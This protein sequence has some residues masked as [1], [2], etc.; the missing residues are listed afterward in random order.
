[1]LPQLRLG[2]TTATIAPGLMLESGTG[3][4]GGSTMSLGV[5]QRIPEATLR[6][7]GSSALIKAY[8]DVEALLSVR[9]I[10]RSDLSRLNTLFLQGGRALSYRM[11]RLRDNRDSCVGAGFCALGCARQAR[12]DAGRLLHEAQQHG[13]HLIQGAKVTGLQVR[14]RRIQG[15]EGIADGRQFSIKADR[16]ILAAGAVMS[17]MLA[18]GVSRGAGHGLFFHPTARVLGLFPAPVVG[19]EG[20]PRSVACVQ[21]VDDGIWLSPSSTHPATLAGWLP[22]STEA[23][24]HLLGRMRSL[25]LCEVAV[26]DSAVGR[27]R[28]HR[29]RPQVDYAVSASARAALAKGVT[30][31]ARLWLAAGARRVV[32]PWAEPAI[33]NTLADA[34]LL[35][36]ALPSP[37]DPL[38]SRWPGG[39]LAAV[40]DEHG[41]IDG[42]T[43][44]HAADTALLPEATAVPPILTAYALG[45]RVAGALTG[46]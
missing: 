35:R 2:G 44:L 12:V 37:E 1:M 27:V 3:P 13:A 41:E 39:G 42:I 38:I 32:I 5:C 14:K 46:Q 9:D 10:P 28:S 36:T 25:A 21:F 11:R 6:R 34:E 43:G 7:W 30:E 23:R 24:A 33:L 17:S 20:I 18:T 4:G 45:W 26:A 16:V 40:S 15:V 31:A 22:G 8:D 19:W 29:G